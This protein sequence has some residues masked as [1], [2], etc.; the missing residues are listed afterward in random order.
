MNKNGHREN[1]FIEQY[2]T[3]SF[4]AEHAGDVIWILDLTTGMFKYVSPSV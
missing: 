1:D 4:I 3:N 2:D